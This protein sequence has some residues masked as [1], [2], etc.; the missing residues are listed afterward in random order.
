MSL[1]QWRHQWLFQWPQGHWYTTGQL[2][3]T[4]RGSR[5]H[6][7]AE[8]SSPGCDTSL[9]KYQPYKCYFACN[10]CEKQAR[11]LP[12]MDAYFEGRYHSHGLLPGK[13]NA[14]VVNVLSFNLNS[15]IPPKDNP[16]TIKVQV[17]QSIPTPLQIGMILLYKVLHFPNQP[18]TKMAILHAS[19]QI[20]CN[21]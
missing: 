10:L 8:A 16:R 18:S 6:Y 7:W 11:E 14:R 12:K 17:L 3:S 20:L 19:F 13:G 21:S 9:D 1:T 4:W 15:Y 2:I 5:C